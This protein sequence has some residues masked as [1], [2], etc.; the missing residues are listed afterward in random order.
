MNSQGLSAQ[1]K[2]LL[3]GIVNFV[4]NG[5][6]LLLLPD[7]YKAITVVVFNIIQ[8]ILAFMDPSYAVHLIQTG[9]MAVPTPSPITKNPLQ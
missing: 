1:T 3:H 5:A 7:P 8:L 4:G 9:Q 2:L 6:I